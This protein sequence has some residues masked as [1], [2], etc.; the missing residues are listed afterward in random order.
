MISYSKFGGDTFM[1]RVL[2]LKVNP[3]F[4]NIH[5]YL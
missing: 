5:C 1:F 2:I 3:K 4:E